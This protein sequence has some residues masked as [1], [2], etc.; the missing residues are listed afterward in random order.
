MRISLTSNKNRKVGLFIIG[1]L[2]MSGLLLPIYQGTLE[3]HTHAAFTPS[4]EVFVPAGDF[5]MGCASDLYGF[6]DADN[7]PIH[8]VKLDSFYIDKTEVSNAQYAA[9]Q[10]AGV[11]PAPL[12][13]ASN[14]R[15]NYYTNPQ[16]S[17]YPV[18]NV[19]WNRAKTYCQWQGKRLPT[20]AEWEKAAHGTEL[21]KYPWGNDAFASCQRAN[22]E[23]CLG[24]TV[25]VDRYPQ[26]ASIYGALNMTGNVS[27]WV[28][29]YYT[30]F[31]Y[32]RS[33][34]YN[35]TG[36]TL[37]D[38]IH[39]DE[40]LLRGGSWHDTSNASTTH[41]RL[42][43][44]ETYHYLQLGI[45]CA[46]SGGNTPTP[47][48]TPT[49]TPVPTPTPASMAATVSMEGADVWIAPPGHLTRLSIPTDTITSTLN[50]TITQQYR[51]NI[52]GDRGGNNHFFSVE[53]ISPMFIPPIGMP[54]PLTVTLS[55][56]EPGGIT[57][58]TLTLYRLDAGNWVTSGI[59]VVA[60]TR[61]SITALISEPGEYGLLGRTDHYYLPVITK[62]TP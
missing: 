46:R 51:N 57:Y 58:D 61:N 59:T 41:V 45:R 8:L 7:Q 31:Y 34:Y 35:P 18:I 43:E 47:S 39:G 1:A 2:I 25:A 15:S 11:C 13:V 14:T 19:D 62:N 42:D 26:S 22:V 56:T 40:H 38:E 28:N 30:R 53:A 48:P 29:D 21:R 17:N 52:Q 16:Y 4:E 5:P 9:C 6:C 27:E 24:D 3:A 60:R 36:P 44:S 54:V 23:E 12:A 33:P 10:A 49:Q 50:L 37:G 32:E 20:E 55:Y